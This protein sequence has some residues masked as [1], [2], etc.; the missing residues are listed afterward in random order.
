MNFL[1]HFY[2]DRN[3]PNANIV[4]GSILP[5]LLKNANKS[6]NVHPE[7]HPE[8]FEKDGLDTLLEGWKRHLQVDLLFHSSD[9]FNTKTQQLK[10]L[11][12]PILNDT[13]VRPSF[14]AHIGVELLL[15]HLLVE[16]KKVAINSFYDHLEAV[17][18]KDLTDFLNKS[19]IDDIQ[20]FFKFF[21]SF[22]SSR[23]LLSYQKLEN[24]SYALQRICM[25]L[26]ERPFTEKT[27][28]QL[29]TVLEFY[30]NQLEVDFMI[31]FEEIEN[32]LT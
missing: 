25:R 1:S 23:Y 13:P 27:T 11:L 10:Q 6:W 5:D 32:R 20:L 2:F 14:L 21:N 28:Q 15:D 19:N 9:F 16:H 17:E 26:W 7:K 3:T 31:I 18:N 4:L 12:I 30:K 22:K 8:L 29:T 24:I